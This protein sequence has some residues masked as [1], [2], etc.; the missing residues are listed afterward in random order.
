M[1]NIGIKTADGGFYPI[2]GDDEVANKRVRLAPAREH[3]SSVQIDLFRGDSDEVAGAEYIGSLLL[4]H[5]E[6]T[7][8][9]K[10]EIEL[11]LRL[12]TQ[13]DLQATAND[14]GSGSYQ[15]FSV[16]LD[17]LNESGGFDIPDFSLDDDQIDD[18]MI[19]G[20]LEDID[21][22]SANLDLSMDDD[23][24]RELEAGLQDSNLEPDAE[25]PEPPR[26]EV[27]ENDGFHPEYDPYED[28]EVPAGAASRRPLKAVRRLHPIAKAIILLIVLAAL[29]LIG[30]GIFLLVRG[31]NLPAPQSLL[32]V[33]IAWTAAIG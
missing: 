1:A 13:H 33:L 28:E 31:E 22:A 18:V 24:E 6:P 19:D 17:T 16:N 3:Q 12:D 27:E 20:G 29:G 23:F 5:I 25:L 14:L 8:D 9:G 4:E 15:S 26:F 7:A 2:F 10:R 11:K 30:F 32:P 21:D